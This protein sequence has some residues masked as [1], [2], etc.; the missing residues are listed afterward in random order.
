LANYVGKCAFVGWI[1]AN[2]RTLA[3][4]VN[5]ISEAHFWSVKWWMLLM[6][7]LGSIIPWLADA[8]ICLVLPFAWKEKPNL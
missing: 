8:Y 4:V 3:M 7:R 1:I 2:S 6:S 5:G